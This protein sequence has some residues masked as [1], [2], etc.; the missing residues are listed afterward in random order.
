MENFEDLKQSYFEK[1]KKAFKEANQE[2][3]FSLEQSRIALIVR[4]LGVEFTF[5]VLYCLMMFIIFTNLRGDAFQVALWILNLIIIPIAILIAISW[6]TQY[7]LNIKSKLIKNFIK[8]FDNFKY[9]IS[10]KISKN[11]M[12]NCGLFGEF[13]VCEKDDCFEGFHNNINFNIAEIL[14]KYKKSSGPRGDFEY[15]V[16]KC[17]LIR[18][19]NIRNNEGHTFVISK[20][21]KLFNNKSHSCVFITL[22]WLFILIPFSLL[23]LMGLWLFI[24]NLFITHNQYEIKMSFVLFACCAFF[25][26][27][28]YYKMINEFFKDKASKLENL[29]EVKLEDIEF[30]N[31]YRVY[32]DSDIES[33]YLLNPV[34]MERLDDIKTSFGVKNLKCSF[35]KDKIYFAISSNRNLFEFGNIFTS[36][37]EQ[38]CYD[39]LFFEI[40]SII[41]MIDYFNLDFK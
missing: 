11:E 37:Y 20:N 35:Y 4:L 25:V 32:S 8:I 29:H 34:F 13:D 12:K 10:T 19:D 3:F 1:Y 33:R 17:V 31:K 23:S 41:L 28:S 2:K 21:D 18:F 24:Y 39:K 7:M 9:G 15:K 38:K 16:F 40:L 6:I 14:L 30:L 22:I 27:S 5:L 26:G 36:V